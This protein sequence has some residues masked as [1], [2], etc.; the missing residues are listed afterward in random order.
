MTSNEVI[1][2]LSGYRYT[3]AII[4]DCPP[5]FVWEETAPEVIGWAYTFSS[6]LQAN[7]RS[8]YKLWKWYARLRSGYY[9][10]YP[11]VYEQYAKITTTP[12]D[13]YKRALVDEYYNYFN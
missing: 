7:I 13:E 4:N 2:I 9:E 5:G 1:E 10:N 6:W 11:Y 3:E 8:L 12:G